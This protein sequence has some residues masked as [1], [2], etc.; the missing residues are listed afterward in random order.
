L[1]KPTISCSYAGT[2]GTIANCHITSGKYFKTDTFVWNF[3]YS[4]YV[5]KTKNVLTASFDFGNRVCHTI[6]LT[7]KRSGVASKSATT[8]PDNCG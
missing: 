8:T 4:G 7:V 5:T 1:I 6:Y 3:D 2:T